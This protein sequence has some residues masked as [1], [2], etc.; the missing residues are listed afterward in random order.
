MKMKKTKDKRKKINIKINPKIFQII[1]LVLFFISSALFVSRS[2][3]QTSPP[4]ELDWA[5]GDFYSSSYDI[6]DLDFVWVGDIGEGKESP[7]ITHGYNDGGVLSTIF[8]SL[9]NIYLEVYAI[10]PSTNSRVSDTIF[11]AYSENCPPGYTYID[12]GC[13]TDLDAFCTSFA[14]LEDAEN[15]TNIQLFFNETTGEEEVYYRAFTI[16]GKPPYEY[17]WCSQEINCGNNSD[18]TVGPLSVGEESSFDY[19]YKH[20]PTYT[21]SLEVTDDNEVEIETECSILVLCD[22]DED[23]PG[24][25]VCTSG[26]CEL[27]PVYVDILNLNPQF[28]N[29]GEQCQLQWYVSAEQYSCELYRNGVLI[30]LVPSTTDGIEKED[31]NCDD[32]S[33]DDVYCVGSG[34]FTLIC[35]DLETGEETIA[36]PSRCILNPE[37]KEI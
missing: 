27:P 30:G 5:I 11:C 22:E 34:S 10:D 29:E 7:F 12:G 4:Y 32:D 2:I 17:R 37:V 15:G 19:S 3:G 23:C 31:N 28:I 1:V 35:T 6:S 13:Y 25:E 33:L 8:N 26:I 21:M 36:G 14:T 24:Q 20:G 18:I 16:G 9:S